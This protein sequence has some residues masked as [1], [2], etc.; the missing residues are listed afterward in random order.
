MGKIVCFVLRGLLSLWLGRGHAATSAWLL[1]VCF[2]VLLFVSSFPPSWLL[3]VWLE[4]TRIWNF[5]GELENMLTQDW[6]Q[7]DTQGGSSPVGEAESV[8]A[9]VALEPWARTR[10]RGTWHQTSWLNELY[11]PGIMGKGPQGSSFASVYAQTHRSRDPLH[12]ELFPSALVH[13]IIQLTKNVLVY[14]PS[15]IVCFIRRKAYLTSSLH[16]P[17]SRQMYRNA[18]IGF[19][20]IAP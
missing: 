8:Q 6:C 14:H 16:W 13:T 11:L 5:L 7:T 17:L 9:E 3:W 19:Y 2:F 18:I 20:G 10:V 1:A 12:F 15:Y 4:R